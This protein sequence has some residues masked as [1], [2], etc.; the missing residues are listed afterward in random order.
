M[1]PRLHFRFSH[2]LYLY[3]SPLDTQ[4][5]GVAGKEF[6]LEPTHEQTK[7]MGVI[8]TKA[9]PHLVPALLSYRDES[10]NISKKQRKEYR[11]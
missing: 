10:Q 6:I 5:S 4:A 3:N 11:K 7:T 1:L 9:L 2:I 8:M